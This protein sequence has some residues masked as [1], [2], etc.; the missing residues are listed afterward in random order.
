M[1]KKYK[2]DEVL[3]GYK[4]GNTKPPPKIDLDLESTE[5]GPRP[6]QTL[7]SETSIAG[8]VKR[9][10]K[11]NT[12]LVKKFL[13]LGPDPAAAAAAA[14]APKRKS[15]NVE[16]RIPAGKT[17]I[18]EENMST[19]RM[20]ARSRAGGAKTNDQVVADAVARE[21]ESYKRTYNPTPKARPK[22]QPFRPARPVSHT[23]SKSTRPKH[24]P[25][26]GV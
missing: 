11:T 16:N 21:G 22:K 14:A 5:T 12:P 1:V 13:G 8:R 9:N 6:Q 24:R 19:D 23:P 2:P 25:K 4:P 7:R 10:V 18:Y 26:P 3:K 17:R 20:I 15:T